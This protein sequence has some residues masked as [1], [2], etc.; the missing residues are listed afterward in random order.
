M[1][2]LS[3]FL[4]GF[5][6][7][8]V[9]CKDNET[10]NISKIQNTKWLFYDF[11]DCQN[12]YSF[13]DSTFKYNSCEIMESFKGSMWVEGDTVFLLIP[14]PKKK[15]IVVGGDSVEIYEERY[16]SARP[17]LEK[18]FYE[19]DTLFF[20]AV[21]DNYQEKNQSKHTDFRIKYLTRYAE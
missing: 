21:I 5:I 3:V 9:S 8:I 17:T 2:R 19:N 18:L 7:F 6:I 12:I 4:I 14:E 1:N 16:Y 11:G 10:F 13:Q 20:Y 15:K